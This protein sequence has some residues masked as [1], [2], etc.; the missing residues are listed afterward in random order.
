MAAPDLPAK[1]A[2]PNGAGPCECCGW[3]APAL[4]RGFVALERHHVVPRSAG[5]TGSVDNMVTLCPN[6][7]TIAHR[8][9]YRADEPTV[10]PRTKAELLRGLAGI[11]SRERP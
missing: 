11:Y 10:W 3:R 9:L 2:W 5:G 6:C 1:V 4:R 8:A 7:H